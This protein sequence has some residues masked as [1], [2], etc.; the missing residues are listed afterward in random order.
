[1]ISVA[2]LNVSECFLLIQGCCNK[3]SAREEHEVGESVLEDLEFGS[4]EEK[5]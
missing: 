5:G 1:M 4:S 2:F 3:E